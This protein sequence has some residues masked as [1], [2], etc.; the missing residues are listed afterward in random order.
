[1]GFLGLKRQV[2][3]P[4]IINIAHQTKWNHL[5]FLGLGLCFLLDF[6]YLN[7]KKSLST[8]FQY[9]IIFDQLKEPVAGRK[10]N[11]IKK[12]GLKLQ[13][14]LAPLNQNPDYIPH[15]DK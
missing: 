11:S 8:Q 7:R 5:A 6:V 4:L 12:I 10:K 1:M 9:H 13:P 3:P 2:K 15:N 14:K